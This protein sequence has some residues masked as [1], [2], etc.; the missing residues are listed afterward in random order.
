[1]PDRLND[2]H[3]G[4]VACVNMIVTFTKVK[5]MSLFMYL[6][7]YKKLTELVKCRNLATNTSPR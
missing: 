3:H 4:Y 5:L 1:M 6:L 2:V 7:E